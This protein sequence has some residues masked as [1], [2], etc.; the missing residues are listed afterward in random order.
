M[1]R[2]QLAAFLLAVPVTLSAQGFGLK[3]GASFGNISNK[4]VLPG[5]LDH[6]PGFAAGV[7]LGSG[8]LIGIGAEGLY[9]QRGLK[10]SSTATEETRLDYLDIPVYVKVALPVPGIRPFAYAGPQVSYEVRCRTAAGDPCGAYGSTDRKK[11]DY[12]GVIGAG[13]RFGGSNLGIGVE[14]RYV[15]GL[16]DLK[17][18]T[19]TS[20]ESY[21]TRSFLILASIG[22]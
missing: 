8:G 11:W 3:A 20:S 19:I 10:G 17:I 18:S 5:N 1:R 22:R 9:A 14:G 12:A 21:Q 2:W 6:R 15:Y 13:V 7:Y 16:R 4:G